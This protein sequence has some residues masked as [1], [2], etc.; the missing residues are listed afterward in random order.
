MLKQGGAVLA[1]DLRAYQLLDEH[2]LEEVGEYLLQEGGHFASAK[3]PRQR[4]RDRGPC[5]AWVMGRSSTL[6][7]VHIDRAL[8][9]RN[10]LELAPASPPGFETI[11]TLTYARHVRM[12]VHARPCARVL[13]S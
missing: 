6:L 9:V 1:W 5:G 2:L 10:T 7:C 12:H 4:S 13:L 3:R 11:S 8:H